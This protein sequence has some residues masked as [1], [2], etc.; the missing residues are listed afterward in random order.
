MKNNRDFYP[1]EFSIPSAHLCIS[2]LIITYPYL[3]YYLYQYSICIKRGFLKKPL[4]GLE[5]FL[6]LER[7]GGAAVL[8]LSKNRSDFCT[9]LVLKWGCRGMK[10]HDQA[11]V[12]SGFEGTE[13]LLADAKLAHRVLVSLMSVAVYTGVSEL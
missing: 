1:P 6:M 3:I 12:C 4:R 8:A 7:S 9:V 10:S 13:N 5:A 11:S 2:E